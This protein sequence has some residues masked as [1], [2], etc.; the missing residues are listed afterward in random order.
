MR[1]FNRAVARN[2]SLALTY[3]LLGAFSGE[4]WVARADPI[5]PVLNPADS[6]S[7]TGIQIVGQTSNSA[8]LEGQ[9]ASFT[10]TV[11]NNTANF[12]ILDLAALIIGTPTIPDFTDRPYNPINVSFAPYIAPGGIGVYDYTASSG[13]L[14]FGDFGVSPIYFQ[15][16]MSEIAGLPASLPAVENTLLPCPAP[17]QAVGC[18][19]DTFYEPFLNPPF[20]VGPQ[21]EA[22]NFLNPMPFRV[23]DAPE[24]ATLAL[25]GIALLGLYAGKRRCDIQRRASFRRA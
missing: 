11:K 20:L 7:P 6:N 5:L 10:F 1:L 16:F 18:I 23:N 17:A 21:H 8:I 2:V 9:Q 12:L 19:V 25:V 3:A 24:P 22:D 14:D 13:P 4:M 15:I